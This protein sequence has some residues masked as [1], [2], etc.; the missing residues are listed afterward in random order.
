M[1]NSGS[2]RNIQASDQALKALA[3][4]LQ[5]SSHCSRITIKEEKEGVRTDGQAFS[6]HSIPNM[7]CI[8]KRSG[9]LLMAPRLHYD[10]KSYRHF[11]CISPREAK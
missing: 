3:F 6:V 5:F 7:R 2:F 10:E 9:V 1:Q 11:I 8:G 4:Y